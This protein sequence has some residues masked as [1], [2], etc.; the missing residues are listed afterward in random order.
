MT[1]WDVISPQV[2]KRN[3]FYQEVLVPAD[4]LFFCAA[5]IEKRNAMFVTLGVMRS[6][7]DGYITP[8]QRQ[9]S[10][11]LAPP[12]ENGHSPSGRLGR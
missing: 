2:A 5:V 12:R 7:A 11:L 4:A 6:R 3:P 8:A 1:D 9:T 10:S